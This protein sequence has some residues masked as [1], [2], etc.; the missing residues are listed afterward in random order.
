LLSIENR[1]DVPKMVMCRRAVRERAKAAKEL[2]LLDA[3]QGDFGEAL[4]SRQHGEQAQQKDLVE[5]VAHLALLARVPEV[6]EMTQEHGRF[7][8]CRTLRRHAVRC[9]SPSC[10]SRIGID[11]AL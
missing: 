3:E 1:Q 2:K 5:R 9:C 6:L 11:S 7:V 10:E 4:C 8:E